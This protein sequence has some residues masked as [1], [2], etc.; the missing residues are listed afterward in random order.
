MEVKSNFQLV[1]RICG[2]RLGCVASAF[3]E[4]SE[5]L[6]ASVEKWKDLA[7]QEGEHA[8]VRKQWK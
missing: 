4:K 7:N 2:A 5:G 1:Q 8:L 6:K 3:T